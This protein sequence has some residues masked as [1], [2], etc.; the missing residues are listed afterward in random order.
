LA[1]LAATLRRLIARLKTPEAAFHHVEPF[2][3]NAIYWP[4]ASSTF[5]D[6]LKAPRRLYALSHARRLMPFAFT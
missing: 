5:Y 3:F 2:H 4:L 1:P 6:T